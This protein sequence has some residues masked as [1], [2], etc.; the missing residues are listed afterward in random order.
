MKCSYLKFKMSSCSANA[1][2]YIPSDFQLEEYCTNA[3][4]TKCPFM[5][6]LRSESRPDRQEYLTGMMGNQ[7]ITNRGGDAAQP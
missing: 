6:A 1:A 5:N 7:E 3:N 2:S 4:H